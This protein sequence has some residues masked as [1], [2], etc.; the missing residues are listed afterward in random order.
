MAYIERYN[1]NPILKP[2]PKNSFENHSV[3]NACPIALDRKKI[4]LVYRAME[5][6]Q[7]VDGHEL[8][9]SSIGYAESTDYLNFKKENSL[10][11]LKKNGSVLA[12]KTLAS[13]K[14]MVNILSFILPFLNT[15]FVQ[16]G[17]KSE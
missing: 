7:T 2:N 17:L 12:V 3:F 8:N 13:L 4:G 11:P 16:K 14:S 9:L 1:K 15:H 5:E 10:L 6:N